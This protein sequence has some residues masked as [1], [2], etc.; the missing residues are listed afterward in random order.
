MFKAQRL[1]KVGGRASM[2][3]LRAA[4]AAA[5]WCF[6]AVGLVAFT[7]VLA[8]GNNEASSPL[9]PV[10]AILLML[11]GFVLMV[12][13]TWNAHLFD[14]LFD[15]VEDAGRERRWNNNVHAMVVGVPADDEDT[16]AGVGL[17]ADN[18]D[19]GAEVGLPADGNIIREFV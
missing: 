16:G 8:D 5:C 13:W 7:A 1:H 11:G 12:I 17:P 2:P 15:G 3:N 10:M 19:T 18:E 9:L 4:A 6:L 14:G